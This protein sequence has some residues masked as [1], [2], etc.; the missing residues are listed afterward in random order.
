MLHVHILLSNCIFD[1]LPDGFWGLVI[2]QLTHVAYAK[3]RHN[4]YFYDMVYNL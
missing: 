2:A 3:L 1:N 4:G